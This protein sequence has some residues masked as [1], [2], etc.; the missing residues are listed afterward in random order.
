MTTEK[1]AAANRRN[2][3]KSTGPRT[4][5]GKA[6]SSQNAL[7]HGLSAERVV[8][9]DEKPADFQA[10]QSALFEFYQ[11]TG[12]VAEHLVAHVAGCIWRLRRVPEIEA[13]IYSCFTLEVTCGPEDE[14]DDQ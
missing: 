2:A 8:I 11:P 5:E 9:W 10:L 13:A 7:K 14:E 4:D 6:S 12:P 3:K 1:Q